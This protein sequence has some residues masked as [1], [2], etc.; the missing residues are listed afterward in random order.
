[1]SS[2]RSAWRDPNGRSVRVY[3][4][5]LESHAWRVLGWSA[6][7]LFVDLRVKLN[8]SNNGNINATL[9]QL[10]HRGW[11]SPTTLS[12]ALYELQAV[13]LLVKLRG[14]GVEFGSKVC[15]LYAFT[16]LDV[17]D[18]PKLGISAMK[19]KHTYLTFQTLAE[20][21]RA[22]D[23][24]VKRMRAEAKERKCKATVRQE[25]TLQNLK[26][27]ATENVATRPIY[28]TESVAESP[29]SLQIL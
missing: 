21:A 25:T 6:R 3:C 23:E 29:P 5:L 14:G 4:T 17:F 11:A 19:A 7:A 13:G 22:R 8:G 9:S 12:K 2:K 1:M 18:H 10:K 28:A 26:H 15:A 24:G 16:D 27:T 20:A